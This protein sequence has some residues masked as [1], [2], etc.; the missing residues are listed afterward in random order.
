MKRSV[1]TVRIPAGSAVTYDVA[2]TT[3]ACEECAAFTA[4]RF[5]DSRIA[6]VTDTNVA[7][8]ALPKL[9]SAFAGNRQK[10]FVH[11]IPAGE[12]HKHLRTVEN[13]VDIFLSKRY[14][15]DTVFI[16]L[17]GG[18]VGDMTGFA[19]SLFARGVPFIQMPTSV[20]SMVDA[21]VGGKTGVD[22]R[23]GKNLIGVFAQPSAVFAD[24]SLLLTLPD[25][26][27]RFGLSEVVKHA[28]ICDKQLFGQ[29]R[30][31]GTRL[32]ARDTVLLHDVIARNIA[33]KKAV[34]EKDEREGGLRQILNFGHT[35]G[36]AI[37]RN[38]NYRMNHGEAVGYGILYESLIARELEIL[39]ESDVGQIRGLLSQLGIV[40][41]RKL[42]L[43]PKRII[44][45]TKSDKKSLLG[46]ARYVL[47][48]GIGSVH[49]DGRRYSIPVKDDIVRKV[50]SEV[51]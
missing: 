23:H 30:K 25:G 15:R 29:L 39:P 48:N 21:S 46:E 12:R 18:V 10:P 4:K 44:E 14:G 33:I 50:L 19:A 41:K 31:N 8:F 51:E 2:V 7:R 36:H 9:L 22:T 13:I 17:G 3:R 49:R 35:I 5:P 37:E 43:D 27:Y 45:F 26:E 47:I 20:V 6:L 40:G 16:A 24:P 11:V 32:L 42:R 38:S 28:L 34:V 1:V